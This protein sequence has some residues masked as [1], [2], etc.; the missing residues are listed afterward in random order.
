M[1]RCIGVCMQ[2]DI[3]ETFAGVSVSPE[4]I[5]AC[6]T[7]VNGKAYAPVEGKLIFAGKWV[8]GVQSM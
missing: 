6:T 4:H 8:V 3:L 5:L 1:L 2:A 7:R